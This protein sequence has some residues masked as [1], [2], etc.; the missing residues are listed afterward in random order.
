[1]KIAA[2][3]FDASQEAIVVTDGDNNIISIN[4]AFTTLTGWS[5][6]EVK[7]RNP[8]SLNQAAI[9]VLFIPRCGRH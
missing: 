2:A 9:P 7:G 6:E 5:L 8:R 3:V 4:P 1:M